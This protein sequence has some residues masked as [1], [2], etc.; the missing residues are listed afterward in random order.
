MEMKLGIPLYFIKYHY[1]VLHSAKFSTV[2]AF[3]HEEVS[4]RPFPLDISRNSFPI[5]FYNHPMN[6]MPTYLH[7]YLHT[8]TYI[9]IMH[10]YSIYK[11]YIYIYIYILTSS[12]VVGWER[13][14]MP[15]PHFFREG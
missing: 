10:I 7:T 11:V 2:S 1:D 6:T 3:W 8:L 4:M 14:G 9:H 12:G 13:R 15:F 5:P